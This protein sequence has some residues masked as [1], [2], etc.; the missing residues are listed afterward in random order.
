MAKT[1]FV[2]FRL[3]KAAVSMEQILSHYE[4]L[5]SLRGRGSQRRGICPIHRGKNKTQFSVNLDKN[6]WQCFS[7]CHCGGDI[8][9]FVS[10]MEN[11]DLRQAALKI[12]DWFGLH[13]E[14]F[15]NPPSNSGKIF[16][17]PREA[18]S[19]PISSTI[20]SVD[21]E[22]NPPLSSLLQNLNYSHPYLTGRGMTPDA[23]AHFGIGF[24]ADQTSEICG[25]IAIPIRNIVGQTVAYAARFTGDP[26]NDE[27]KYRFPTGFRKRVELYNAHEAFA[28]PDREPFF[29]V[30]GFFGCA[31]VWH[32]GGRRIVGLMGSSLSEE[33]ERL[34][35]ANT[36]SRTHFI[37]VLDEDKAGRE[38]RM[39]IAPRLAVHRFVRIHRFKEEG[40]QAEHLTAEEVSALIGGVP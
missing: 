18:V 36:T 28:L 6:V 2:D 13:L 10:R 34:L 23:A 20:E 27:A 25:K 39:E 40:R 35:I 24:C 19:P 38:G 21:A 17:P 3:V 14:E 16:L 1:Q 30:E 11:V 29:V 7:D 33:Q 12:C 8:L 32:H 15:N 5:P 9:E 37:L 4:L 22:P 31:N 26:P